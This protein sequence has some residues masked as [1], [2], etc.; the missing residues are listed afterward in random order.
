MPKDV[1]KTRNSYYATMAVLYNIIINKKEQIDNVDIIFTSLCCGYGKMDEIYSIT[2][3][4][5]QIIQSYHHKRTHYYSR[6]KFTGT[7]KILSKH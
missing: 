6:T 1:S 5:Q 2:Q 3:I 4:I 7:T